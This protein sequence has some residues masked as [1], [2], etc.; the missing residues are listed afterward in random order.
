MDCFVEIQV[1]QKIYELPLEV[2]LRNRMDPEFQY[3]SQIHCNY[4]QSI[5]N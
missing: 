4:I 5:M 2:S 1:C 3:C